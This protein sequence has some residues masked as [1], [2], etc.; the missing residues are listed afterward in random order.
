MAA[1]RSRTTSA[2][3]LVRARPCPPTSIVLNS[4][5]SRKA[6]RNDL[7]RTVPA[8]GGQAAE[9]LG[10]K[11]LG[12]RGGESSHLDL[13]VVNSPRH[14]PWWRAMFGR[15]LRTRARRRHCLFFVRLARSSFAPIMNDSYRC[16]PPDTE[17]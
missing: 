15:M 9:A 3:L 11:V 14:D 1:R 16:R 7:R 2:Y 12:L 8:H 6:D 17:R 5:L 10:L 13:Q 4:R